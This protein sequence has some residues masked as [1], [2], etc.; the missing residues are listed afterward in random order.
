MGD[1]NL[2]RVKVKGNKVTTWLNGHKM[3]KLVDTK[4]G[5]VNGQIA[6]QIHEGGGIK[7]RWRNLFVKK[8]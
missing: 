7:I 3:I 6:L 1:W 2:L 4:I 5:S 8:L